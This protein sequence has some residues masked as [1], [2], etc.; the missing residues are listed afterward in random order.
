MENKTC[1]GLLDHDFPSISSWHHVQD[2]A[3]VQVKSSL[4]E[5][6]SQNWFH[7]HHSE[8]HVPW[9]W[10][11]WGWWQGLQPSWLSRSLTNSREW[12]TASWGEPSVPR[13]GGKTSGA[14]IHLERGEG[15]MNIFSP[16]ARWRS[17]DFSNGA[18][19]LSLLLLL[20]LC[21]W[22]APLAARHDC[23]FQWFWAISQALEAAGNAWTGTHA[24]RNA[25]QNVRL[26][27]MLH[28]MPKRLPDRMSE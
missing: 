12:Q 3:D 19:P 25:G 5:G 1:V 2:A 11:C 24:R 4:G 28:R 20:L 15:P 10:R 7:C 18:T 13:F 17:L 6:G 9:L 8:H 26:L 22:C 14:R 23:G 21:S 16:P 27:Y